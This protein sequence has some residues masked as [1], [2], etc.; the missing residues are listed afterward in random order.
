[1]ISSGKLDKY[2][3]FQR[4]ETS[5]DA[6]GSPAESWVDI[7]GAPHWAEFIPVRGLE[8]IEASKINS[9]N[10][11]K[12]RVRR[13]ASLS[14]KNRMKYGERIFKILGIEDYQPEGEMVL[15]CEEVS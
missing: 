6:M 4:V 2:V 8:R 5:A 10:P 9:V 3:V 13:F 11:L 1:M 14:S 7:G 12:V 15:H